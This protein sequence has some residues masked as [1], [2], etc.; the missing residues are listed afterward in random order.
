[1]ADARV[2]DVDVQLYFYMA[3]SDRSLAINRSNLVHHYV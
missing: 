1:M 2:V 3:K